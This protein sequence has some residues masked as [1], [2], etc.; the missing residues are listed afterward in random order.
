MCVRQPGSNNGHIVPQQ[1]AKLRQLLSREPRSGR[2]LCRH[3]LRST[4]PYKLPQTG[5]AYGLG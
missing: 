4:Q 1:D 3:L 2:L 5:V